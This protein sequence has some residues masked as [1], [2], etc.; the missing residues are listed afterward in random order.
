MPSNGLRST[1]RSAA[2]V[3]IAALTLTL[4]G[5]GGGQ[6]FADSHTGEPSLHTALAGLGKGVSAD[7]S[8]TFVIRNSS[9]KCLEITNSSTAN[10]ADAQQWDCKGQ[11]GSKWRLKIVGNYFQVV[12]AHSNKCLEITDSS[13]RNGARAQ[14]WTC[15]DQAGSK[16]EIQD[17]PSAS[18]PLGRYLLINH[19]RKVLEITSSSHANGDNAQQWLFSGQPGAVWH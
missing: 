15:N 3:G 2:A 14:Q 12:N 19:S 6:A 13:T 11:A 8:G 5:L 7:L 18:D 9:G 17:Y 1:R 4:S 16:W 10:G